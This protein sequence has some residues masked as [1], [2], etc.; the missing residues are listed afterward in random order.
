ME[1][2]KGKI[3]SLMAEAHWTLPEAPDS[4]FNSGPVQIVIS[5]MPTNNI[6]LGHLEFFLEHHCGMPDDGS[7]SLE[8]QED[9]SA[10]VSF[11]SNPLKTGMFYVHNYASL[12]HVLICFA[13]CVVTLCS[14]PKHVGIVLWDLRTAV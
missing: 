7:C 3:F 9:V 4:T 10:L 14:V 5:N 1:K 11:T 2:K 8:L 6:T 12:L 13:V